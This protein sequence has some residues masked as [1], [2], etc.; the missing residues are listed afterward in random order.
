MNGLGKH[1][2]AFLL[3]VMRVSA[4]ACASTAK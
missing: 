1:L 4:A 2:A 3:A